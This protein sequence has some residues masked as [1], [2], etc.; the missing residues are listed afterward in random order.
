MNRLILESRFDILT[1]KWLF[2]NFFKINMKNYEILKSSHI[3]ASLLVA[4]ATEISVR[5]RRLQ[6]NNLSLFSIA[7]LEKRCFRKMG[8]GRKFL[9]GKSCGVAS[10]F[11]FNSVYRS[12]D[13]TDGAMAVLSEAKVKIIIVHSAS[14]RT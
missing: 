9:V 10:I 8:L 2:L 1:V 13:G 4:M 11:I 12:D 6:F 14:S 5:L 3:P 7:S